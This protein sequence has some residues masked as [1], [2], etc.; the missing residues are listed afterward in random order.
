MTPT[1]KYQKPLPATLPRSFNVYNVYVN[2]ELGNLGVGVKSLIV[3]K[4]NGNIA[5]LEWMTLKYGIT[6][7]KFFKYLN[8]ER[9]KNA[10]VAYIV[11]RIE[12][13][14]FKTRVDRPILEKFW[15]AIK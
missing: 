7:D 2:E 13:R 6:S 8:P 15:K 1:V 12:K 11:S 4:L 14:L 10:N 9:V 3:W 5:Y